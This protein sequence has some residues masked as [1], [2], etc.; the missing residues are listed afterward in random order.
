MTLLFGAVAWV[1]LR[2]AAVARRRIKLTVERPT[3]ALW[4]TIGRAGSPPQD[5]ARAFALYGIILT[6]VSWLVVPAGIVFVVSRF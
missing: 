6:A 4:E 2:G 5:Q 3:Q 1:I